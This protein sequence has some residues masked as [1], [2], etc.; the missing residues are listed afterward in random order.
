MNTSS[1]QPQE[2]NWIENLILESR[3]DLV[4]LW[5]LTG[6]RFGAP[7][8][9]KAE[10]PTVLNRAISAL[11]AKDC[12]IGFGDPDSPNWRVPEELLQDGKPAASKVVDLWGKH[13]AEY[14]FLVFA[15][16]PGSE[17]R[18]HDAQPVIPR[19]LRDK[20]AL[21]REFKL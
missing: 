3:R 10:L 9:T 15:I 6:G 17:S 1:P 19:S 21:S 11:L 4:F 14:E 2:E 12:K 8:Y 20:A 7:S 5:H 16:R 18:N 13:P